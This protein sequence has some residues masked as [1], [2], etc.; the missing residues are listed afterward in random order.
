MGRQLLAFI[1]DPLS[2]LFEGLQ[3]YGQSPI[4]IVAALVLVLELLYLEPDS[5]DLGGTGVGLPF[6]VGVAP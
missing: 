2:L 5:L 3:G 4:L 1:F 6:E